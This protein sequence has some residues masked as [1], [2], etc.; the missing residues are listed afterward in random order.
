MEVATAGGA[1]ALTAAK[2]TDKTVDAAR[3]L[4]KLDDLGDA[5]KATDKLE[6][7]SDGTKLLPPPKEL[8]DVVHVPK[9]KPS[10]KHGNSD[11]GPGKWQKE[12]TPQKGADY[13]E[14]VTGAPK[15]TEYV[16]K[17]DLMKSGKKKF[18]GYDPDTNT[19]LDAKEWDKW[20]PK[21]QDW[22]EKKVAKQAQIDAD[23]AKK[24]GANLEY[25]VPSQEK[26]NQL[27]KIFKKNDVKGIKVTVTPK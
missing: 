13:Q 22:A 16:V 15:D 2:V 11:G 10:Y 27:N 4:D 20:P 12:T 8:G 25:R 14:K 7:I 19:L 21:G 1:A 24:A 23:I 3:V 5:A 17:T 9:K 26:A 18:D 6:D